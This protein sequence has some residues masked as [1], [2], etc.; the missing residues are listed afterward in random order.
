MPIAPR[1]RVR[2]VACADDPRAAGKTGRIVDE[3]PPGPLT[4][5]RWTVKVDA[6]FIGNVLCPS[7]ELAPI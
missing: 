1:A 7:S 4:A 2:I 3:V 6:F 5:G